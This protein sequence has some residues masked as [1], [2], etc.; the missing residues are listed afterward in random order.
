MVTIALHICSQ[1]DTPFV[2]VAEMLCVLP[3]PYAGFIHAMPG[4]QK[5]GNL[6]Q[7]NTYL[8]WM[9]RVRL[10]DLNHTPACA[11]EAGLGTGLEWCC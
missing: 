10:R 11:Q 4:K 8:M 7:I 3:G 9:L 6:L 5:G 2:T 1:M